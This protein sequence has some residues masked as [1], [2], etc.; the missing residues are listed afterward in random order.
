MLVYIIRR[1]VMLIPILFL[2]S[3]IAFF[4]IELPPG[5]WVSTYI[6]QLR[7][8]GIELSDQ[9]AQRLITMYGFDQPAYMRYFKWVSGIVTRG[10][11]GW[12]F[13]WGKPVSEVIAERLPITLAISLMA[14]IFSW[15]IAIPIGI[16]SATHQYSLVDYLATFIGFIGLATPGFLLAMILAWAANQYLGF[17]AL[18]LYSKEFL[19]KPWSLAKAID[20]L[21]HMILP[22]VIIGMA[23]AGSTIRVLRGN[24]LD[25][26]KKQYVVTARAKGVSEIRLLFKYPVRLALNPVF[27]T[28]G[29][30]LPAIF[31]GE[32]L[33]SIVL[34]V[35][36][37]GPLLLRATLAQDMY[38]T[39]SIVLILSALTIIGSLISDIYLAWADPRIRY[40]GLSK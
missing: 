18:G 24:L 39:G 38:L 11:F 13:Q 37:I 1:L 34:S 14:L 12:S 20:M 17:S 30:L 32:V 29:W 27:S 28:I 22:L 15:L 21:K 25:E 35:P 36:S 31:A 6:T 16:Y 3:F 8:S 40:G 2:V 19:D 23:S 7:T 4:V 26:L 33:I 5:D 10:D 9:E